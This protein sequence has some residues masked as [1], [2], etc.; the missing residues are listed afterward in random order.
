MGRMRRGVTGNTDYVHPTGTIPI[1]FAEFLRTAKEVCEDHTIALVVAPQATFE[2]PLLDSAMKEQSSF[3][4]SQ[5][6]FGLW[7]L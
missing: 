6:P 3:L 5:R 1:T 4:H 7:R 2:R